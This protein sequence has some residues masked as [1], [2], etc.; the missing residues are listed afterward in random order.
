MSLFEIELNKEFKI[1]DTIVFLKEDEFK[2]YYKLNNLN[3]GYDDNIEQYVNNYLLYAK[4]NTLVV[5]RGNF[6]EDKYSIEEIADYIEQKIVFI[7]VEEA[8]TVRLYPEWLLFWVAVTKRYTSFISEHDF[9]AYFD[10]FKYISEIRYK[11]YVIRNLHNFIPFQDHDKLEEYKTHLNSPFSNFLDVTK[12]DQ[13]YLFAFLNFLYSMHYALKENEKYKLMWNLETY[14]IEAIRLL[15]DQN[16]DLKDIYLKVASGIRG[17][18]SPLHEV[19]LHKPLYIEESKHYFNLFLPLIKTLFNDE[20]STDELVLILREDERFDDILFS[21]LELTKRFNADKRNEVVM[22][23]MIKGIV[24]GLEELIRDEL[25]CSGADKFYFYEKCIKKLAL[26]S[27]LLKP[28]YVLI[29]PH[30]ANSDFFTKLEVLCHENE[31]LEKLLMVYYHARNYLA[32]N[33]IDM[34]KF[35]WGDDGRRNIIS[36]VLNAIIVILYR[37]RKRG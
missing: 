1:L 7:D 30:I 37:L 33:N 26:G 18:Y 8:H 9:N 14:I 32:H 15:V 27:H 23:A 36:N 6:V 11:R 16:I 28:Y 2:K 22:G 25:D 13:E 12:F 34:D 20:I 24:L 35:F 31:S 10:G 19:Y 17:T 4:N 29:E 5:K 21:F 3:D